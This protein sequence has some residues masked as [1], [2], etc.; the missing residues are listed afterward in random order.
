MLKDSTRWPQSKNLKITLIFYIKNLGVRKMNLEKLN[1]LVPANILRSAESIKEINSTLRAAHFLSQCAH[2]SNDFKS[3][4][5][6]LNYSAENLLKA[7]PKYFST[8][9][10]K[11]Y[12]RKP[13][14]IANKAY[15]GRIG[16]GDE[17][18]GDGWRFRGRGLIQ[19]TGRDNY[20]GFSDFV[21]DDCV[22]NPDLLSTKYALESAAWFFN[23]NGIW[24]L[25]DHGS[26]SLDISA[27]TRKVN[28]GINGLDDRTKR[29]N[30]IYAALMAGDKV[31][32]V[33]VASTPTPRKTGFLAWIRQLL[34]AS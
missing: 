13:V 29:F 11:K 14:D 27:V 16:N 30:A 22:A 23:S 1:G 6:N 5:E 18:S 31:K 12:Q 4:I 15:A 28:G 2:E 25:C 21:G 20:E 3:T 9:T 19:I 7:F 34:S 32:P 26:C 8:E 17:K 33:T 10:S 24:A